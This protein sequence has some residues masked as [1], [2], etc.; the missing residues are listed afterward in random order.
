MPQLAHCEA[1]IGQA[2]TVPTPQHPMVPFLV[3]LEHEFDAKVE[4]DYDPTDFGQVRHG[5]Q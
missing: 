2:G 3:D 1:G 5:S 4:R